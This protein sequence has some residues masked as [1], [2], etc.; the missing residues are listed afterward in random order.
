MMPQIKIIF[1][2]NKY[3]NMLRNATYCATWKNCMEAQL[4]CLI[5]YTIT[6]SDNSYHCSHSTHI[7]DTC[8]PKR[9]RILHFGKRKLNTAAE[10]VEVLMGDGNKVQQDSQLHQRTSLILNSRNN[11]L[12]L[13]IP[14]PLLFPPL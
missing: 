9:G 3:K 12:S 1:F 8:N 14:S 10:C 7:K 4:H 6:S 2:F 5:V 13:P 11:C